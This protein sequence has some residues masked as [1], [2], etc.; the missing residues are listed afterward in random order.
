MRADELGKVVTGP[1]ASQQSARSMVVSGGRLCTKTLT[2]A[3]CR[4][5]QY[6]AKAYNMADK[7]LL[8]KDWNIDLTIFIASQKIKNFLALCSIWE[9]GNLLTIIPVYLF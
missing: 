3:C 8:C 5:I 4:E 9:R 7:E 1:L 6:N 2:L